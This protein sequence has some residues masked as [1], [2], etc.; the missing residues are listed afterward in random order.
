MKNKNRK[1]VTGFGIIFAIGLVFLLR[2][3]VVRAAC[4][5]NASSQTSCESSGGTW[6]GGSE[7]CYCETMQCN[8]GQV[9]CV[10]SQGPD[11]GSLQKALNAK[12]SDLQ[13]TVDCIY[14][15]DTEAAVSYFQVNNS[16][17]PDGKA[18]PQTLTALGLG[19]HASPSGADCKASAATSAAT[20][21]PSAQTT[22]N[23]PAANGAS[24][25][26]NCPLPLVSGP[27][28][29]C[30]PQSSFDAKSIA[31]ASTL[32]GLALTVINYL[33]ILAGL[34][35]VIALVIGGFWYITAAGNEEQSEKGRKAIMNAIIG[36][37]VVVLAYAIVNILVD[38]LTT[39]NLL[40]TK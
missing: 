10:G 5:A 2:L 22:S 39:T 30:M 34:I 1:F 31:G 35:A 18:G 32:T 27:G 26:G 13:I 33:L 14:G 21:N 40:N 19:G 12:Q 3:P 8:Q 15:S 23:P 29:L 38:T 20:G 37:V 36:V 24:G 28:G 6:M 16:L 17:A 9:L 7:T 25:A 4:D 11:V